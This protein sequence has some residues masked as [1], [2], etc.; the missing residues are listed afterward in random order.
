MRTALLVLALATVCWSA[1][2]EQPENVEAQ[3]VVAVAPVDLADDVTGVA[4]A[5]SNVPLTR[6]KRTLLLKKLKLAKLGLLGLG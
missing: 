1:V 6:T 2:I 5:S 4:D 3:E